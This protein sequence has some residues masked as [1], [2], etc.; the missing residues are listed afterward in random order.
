VSLWKHIGRGWHAFSSFV[1][2]EVGDGSH[3]KVWHNVW[4]GDH[5]FKES[6]PKLFFLARNRDALVADLRIIHNDVVH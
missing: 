5:S 1:S 2:V 4:C 6:F 3:T